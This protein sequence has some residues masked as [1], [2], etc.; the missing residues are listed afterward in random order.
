MVYSVVLFIQ[1]VVRNNKKISENVNIYNILFLFWK[2]LIGKDN[3]L[4]VCET[5]C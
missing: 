3:K 2:V 4:Y 5:S 1:E